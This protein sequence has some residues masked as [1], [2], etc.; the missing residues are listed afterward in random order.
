MLKN[1]GLLRTGCCDV[2]G[3]N[4]FTTKPEAARYRNCTG[5]VPVLLTTTVSWTR[6]E[7]CC[8]S[9]TECIVLRVHEGPA[10]PASHELDLQ[11]QYREHLSILHCSYSEAFS[12][13][14][15]KVG[16]MMSQIHKVRLVILKKISELKGTIAL[17]GAEGDADAIFVPIA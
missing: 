11:H 17:M 6:S 4:C 8:T 3:Y 16:P 15:V 1:R 7:E 5:C 2:V 12:D 10:R 14:S 9:E 13:V